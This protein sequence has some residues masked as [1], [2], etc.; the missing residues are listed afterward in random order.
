MNAKIA[1]IAN[2]LNIGGPQKGL[3]ALLDELDH[4]MFDVTVISLQRDGELRPYIANRASAVK[5]VSSLAQAAQMNRQ[6][7]LRD[8]SILLRF[9]RL[10]SVWNYLGGIGAR[11]IGRPVN[12]WRQRVWSSARVA[13]DPSLG[14]F[15][16]AFAVSSGLATY[17][18]V[19]CLDS[20]RRFHWI[21]GDYSRTAIDRPIDLKYFAQTD[22]A[23][24]VSAECSEIFEAVFPE[25]TSPIREF[26]QLIPWTFYAAHA[27]TEPTFE[28]KVGALRILTVTRL[29]REKGMDLAVDAC[30]ALAQRGIPVEW[31]V[32]GDGDQRPDIARAIERGGVTQSMRLL[33]F[34]ANVA[35]FLSTTQVFVLPSRTEGRSSAVD[36]AISMGVPV[37]VTNYRTAHSQVDSPNKGII[38]SMDGESIADAIELVTGAPPMGETSRGVPNADPTPL[39]LAFAKD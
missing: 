8:L 11:I 38:C 26:R 20:R 3:V 29:E 13:V 24:S 15:D 14:S 18:L 10:R 6:T 30:R 31:V 33:G 7:P 9:W 12:P 17:F 22:G 19:D 36:E 25:L 2:N 32:L 34:K 27:S 37:V 35:D 5:D 28:G 21:I 39:F 16:A 1:F 23:L 4:A